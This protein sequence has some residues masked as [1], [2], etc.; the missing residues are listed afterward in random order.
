[1]YIYVHMYICIYELSNIRSM[2]IS[3]SKLSSGL[4]FWEILPV[5]RAHVEELHTRL[6]R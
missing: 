6:H 1:M 5:Q 2:V 3:H 4:T